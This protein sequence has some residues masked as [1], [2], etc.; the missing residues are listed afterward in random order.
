M[1]RPS[2]SQLAEI[3]RTDRG[4]EG[5]QFRLNYSE[6]QTKARWVTFSRHFPA[7]VR[8]HSTVNVKDVSE[9]SHVS[10]ESHVTDVSNVSHAV[11]A[12]A[13]VDDPAKAVK[14]AKPMGNDYR[15]VSSYMQ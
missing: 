8:P 15:K 3:P 7:A 6:R 5:F 1:K 10:L 2:R 11:Y 14:V 13:K 12:Y 4:M 9:M